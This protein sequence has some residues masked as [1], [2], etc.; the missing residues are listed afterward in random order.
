MPG[1]NRPRADDQ[2]NGGNNGYGATNER[3]QN[4][5]MDYR[6]TCKINSQR[7]SDQP[8]SGPRHAQLA[9]LIEKT[10]G[11]DRRRRTVQ[12]RFLYTR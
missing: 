7:C 10:S 6:F 4:A 11:V 9:R 1:W 2:R 12:F 5:G 8:Q 3:Y